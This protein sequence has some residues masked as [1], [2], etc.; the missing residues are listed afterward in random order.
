MKCDRPVTSS[1]RQ[2]KPMPLNMRVDRDVVILSNLG[3]LMNDPRYFDA[4]RDMRDMLDQGFRKFIL[5]LGGVREVGSSLLG[6][7]TTMTRQVRQ[8]DGELVLAHLSQDM[9]KFIEEMR[10]DDYWDVFTGVEA[11]SKFLGAGTRGGNLKV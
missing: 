7:L 2:E 9:E 4:S 6:L 8:H 10:M 5:E 3:R 1:K 11:A